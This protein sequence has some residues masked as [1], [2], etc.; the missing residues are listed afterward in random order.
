MRRAL[1]RA[2]LSPLWRKLILDSVGWNSCPKATRQQ[3]HR[4]IDGF[5]Q[6][7]DSNLIGV[8]LHGSLA[9][10]CFN[11]AT[12]DVDLLVTTCYR[13]PLETK[14][15][16]IELLLVVSGL[17]HPIEISFLCQEDLTPWRYPTPYDLHYGEDWRKTFST[18]LATHPRK[19][20]NEQ[21]QVDPDLAAHITVTR[22]RGVCLWG[23]P[24]QQAFPQVPRKDYVASI[25]SDLQWAHD[26]MGQGVSWVYGVLNACRVYAYLRERQILSKAEGAEWALNV[27]PNE[28]HPIINS[29]L[30]TYHDQRGGNSVGDQRMAEQ[31]MDY[32]VTKVAG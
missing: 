9:M 6:R 28:F 3:T 13:I 26:R 32:V 14:I 30:E 2:H 10:N 5:R 15:S 1:A 22:E 7:L 11:P 31:L 12:S 8:Y 23:A 29:A 24:I 20:P 19:Q 27:L 21:P 16:M 17:P 4:L 18:N 25:V